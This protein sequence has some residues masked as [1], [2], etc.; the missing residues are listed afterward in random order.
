MVTKEE[1]LK[2]LNIVEAYHRQI[3]E[4]SALLKENHNLDNN[5]LS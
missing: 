5:S 3:N 2:A 4:A 1:Y